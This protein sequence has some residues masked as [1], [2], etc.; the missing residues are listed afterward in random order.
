MKLART[1]LI[2]AFTLATTLM[3]TAVALAQGLAPPPPLP[4][5]EQKEG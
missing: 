1:S 4:A 3:A 2:A 5:E